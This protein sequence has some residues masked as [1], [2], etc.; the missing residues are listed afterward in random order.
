LT[1]FSAGKLLFLLHIPIIF[2][3]EFTGAASYSVGVIA[4]VRVEDFRIIM[5]DGPSQK[6]ALKTTSPA[7]EKPSCQ[8]CGGF[9]KRKAPTEKQ[10][11]V[12]VDKVRRKE[13]RDVS[14]AAEFCITCLRS[15]YGHEHAQIPR[16]REKP[17]AKSHVLL[18]DVHSKVRH[19]QRFWAKGPDAVVC[20]PKNRQKRPANSKLMS[21]PFAENLAS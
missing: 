1:R 20:K 12:I 6:V 8:A 18:A 5:S 17:E 15:A 11:Q 4:P 10:K 7:M 3:Q 21:G 9:A 16:P 2:L 13:G 19:T 14:S